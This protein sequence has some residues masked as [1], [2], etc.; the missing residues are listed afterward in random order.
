MLDQCQEK[1]TTIIRPAPRPGYLAELDKAE[2]S[3]RACSE[4]GCAAGAFSWFLGAAGGMGDCSEN[5][6]SFGALRLSF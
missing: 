3:W 4:N 1:V 5:V 6:P 2:A